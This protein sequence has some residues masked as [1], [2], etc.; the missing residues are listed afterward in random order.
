MRSRITR[1]AFAALA[2]AG[3]VVGCSSGA[4]PAAPKC[5]QTCMDQTAMLALRQGIKLAYN[6]TFQGQPVGMHDLTTDCPLGGSARIFGNATSNPAQGST[7]V[8]LTYVLT[9]CVYEVKDNDPTRTFKLTFDGTL[10]EKG[11][12]AVQPSSTTALTIK[13]D[14][15]TLSG[16][17]SDPAIPYDATACAMALGQNGSQLSGVFCGR[18]VGLTL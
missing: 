9:K 8:D 17:V 2:L 3:T 1:I 6:L 11:I 14:A 4:T 13:S 7:S 5:D 12:L 15:M 10:T 16:T 18:D